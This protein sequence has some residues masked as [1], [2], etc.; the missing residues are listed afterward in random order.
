MSKRFYKSTDG[1]IT[2]FRATAE[3][4]YQSAFFSSTQIDGGRWV[5]FGPIGFSATGTSG[6]AV[7]NQHAAEEIVQSEYE[8]LVARKNSRLKAEGRDPAGNASPQN[9]WVSNAALS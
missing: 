1:H 3:R 5:R 7:S 2:V 9:S 4:R 6:A 8:T